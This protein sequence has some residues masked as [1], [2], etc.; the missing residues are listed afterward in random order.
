METFHTYLFVE[1]F[2]SIREIYAVILIWHRNSVLQNRM[3]CFNFKF[4][5]FIL[6]FLHLCH[7]IDSLIWQILILKGSE[8]GLSPKSKRNSNFKLRALI[9]F[10]WLGEGLEKEQGYRNNYFFFN[11]SIFA[12]IMKTK[13]ACL[14]GFFY[15]CLFW[16]V[17]TW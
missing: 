17:F 12:G 13:L 16:L 6:W 5:S 8:V 10:N 7:N 3:Q 4:L 1:F 9:C 14:I 15:H 11:S 2:Q